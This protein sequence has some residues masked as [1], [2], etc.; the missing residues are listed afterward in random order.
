M[1]AKLMAALPANGPALWAALAKPE[2]AALVAGLLDQIQSRDGEGYG[3]GSAALWW[4]GS[5]W[6]PLQV[7]VEVARHNRFFELP[8]MSAGSSSSAPTAPGD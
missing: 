5:P 7:A 1:A 4:Q 8:G 3:P 6:E 2:A